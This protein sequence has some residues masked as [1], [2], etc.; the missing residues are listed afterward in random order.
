[1]SAAVG[2]AWVC[3]NGSGPRM[4]AP[5]QQPCHEVVA[6]LD[7]YSQCYV[8]SRAIF[9]MDKGI[10][11]GMILWPPLPAPPNYPLRYAKYQLIET[12]A[13]R[14][15]SEKNTRKKPNRDHKGLNRGTLGGCW[16]D[17]WPG[18]KS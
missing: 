4:E 14:K 12:P 9:R 2:S 5:D 6:L 7:S 3:N 18:E 8:G 10:Y 1:M 16:K 11:I 13:I 17:P 15:G